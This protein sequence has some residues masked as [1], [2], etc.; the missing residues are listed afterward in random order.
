[1]EDTVPLRV[2]LSLTKN[3]RQRLAHD[4]V[5]GTILARRKQSEYF[6]GGLAVEQREDQRLDDAER[7][8]DG[9]RVAPRLEV[10]RARDVPLRLG[11]CLIHGVPERDRLRNLRHGRGEVKI[12]GGV[13]DRIAAQD[14]ERLYLSRL[15]RGDE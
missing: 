1:M 5:T 8:A 7:A 13:E 2:E 11:R 4:L 9:A 10:M 14:D 12:G 15:H 3:R 6:N